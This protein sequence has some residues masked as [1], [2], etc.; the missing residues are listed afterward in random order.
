MP[1]FRDDM[2]PE[3]EF[4][5]IVESLGT[6][7]AFL[8]DAGVGFVPSA[9]G[10]LALQAACPA[11]QAAFEGGPGEARGFLPCLRHPFWSG[12]AFGVW[13]LDNGAAVVWGE[14]ISG[15][16]PVERPFSVE[17]LQQLGRM[18]EWLGKE[19]K[20]VTPGIDG[21]RLFMAGRCLEGGG[22]LPEGAGCAC[23]PL[24]EGWLAKA[25]SRTVLL[26]GGA[27]GS[28]FI[29]PSPQAEP[30]GKALRARGRGLVA[31][32]SP[33]ELVARP[34]LKKEALAHLRTFLETIDAGLIEK[35]GVT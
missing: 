31:T 1:R 14:A 15:Q 21:Y 3:D 5:A 28:A 25:G 2:G 30:L 17:G 19:M 8:R 6:R 4:R 11:G 9:K 27:A 20:A 32:W 10:A 33:D 24:I 26:M 22:S 34:G 23:A 16:G 29:P 18:L 35:P 7:L 12:A 13:A